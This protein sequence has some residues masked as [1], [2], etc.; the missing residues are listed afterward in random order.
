MRLS[1]SFAPTTS[2][3][4]IG[5]VAYQDDDNYVNITRIY[6]GANLVSLRGGKR[7]KPIGG[8]FGQRDGD[9]L[10]SAIGSGSDDEYD[11]RLLLAGQ[12]DLGAGEFDGDGAEQSAVGHLCGRIAERLAERQN[13][14]GA[15]DDRFIG[16]GSDPGVES[17]QRDGRGRLTGTVTL[18]A[19]HRQAEQW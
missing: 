12:C 9:E 15:G 1:L 8:E 14:L 4:Q 6:N 13:H 7:R 3:Q 5:L 18:S 10:L 19:L 17:K 11:H 2:Y 16:I